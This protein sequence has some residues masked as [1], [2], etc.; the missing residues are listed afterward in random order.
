MSKNRAEI[1]ESKLGAILKTTQRVS[2]PK[3]H[4]PSR[5][6]SATVRA[7]LFDDAVLIACELIPDDLRHH[8]LDRALAT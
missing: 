8:Q 5:D 4:G 7:A 1:I 2:I 3:A 6:L